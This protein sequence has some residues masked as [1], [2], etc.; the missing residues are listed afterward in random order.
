MVPLLIVVIILASLGLLGSVI[1]GLLWLTG[2]T[3]LLFV[4]AGYFLWS[5]LTR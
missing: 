5:K 4:G 1:E 3:L 2:L